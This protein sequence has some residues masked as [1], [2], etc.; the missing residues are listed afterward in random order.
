MSLI[1]NP[2]YG[3]LLIIRLPYNMYIFTQKDEEI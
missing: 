3:Q 2:Q 1:G